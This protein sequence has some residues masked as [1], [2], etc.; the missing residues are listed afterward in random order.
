MHKIAAS[1]CRETSGGCEVANTN[2]AESVERRCSTSCILHLASV[3]SLMTADS[4]WQR[5]WAWL[6]L[7]TVR[8]LHSRSRSSVQYLLTAR[9]TTMAT[10]WQATPRYIIY[11]LYRYSIHSA[12]RALS[13]KYKLFFVTTHRVEDVLLRERKKCCVKVIFGPGCYK[14]I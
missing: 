7:G 13:L 10:P 5:R 12:V 1:F 3:C 2:I 4:S 11:N 9:P 6:R 8:W 14:H